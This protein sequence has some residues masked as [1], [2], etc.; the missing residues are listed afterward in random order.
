M[1]I[2]LL[3][4]L[5]Q[6]TV[7]QNGSIQGN[8]TGIDCRGNQVNCNIVKGKLHLYVDAGTSGGGGGAPTN[9]QY[10][11]GTADGTLSAEKNL[12]ALS[13]GLVLNTGG[14]P[15]AY[16]GASCTNQFPRSLNASGA[17]TCA[18]V[19]LAADVTGNLPVANLNSGTS[20]SAT[21][22]WRG[23]GTWAT[24]SSG[25]ANTVETTLALSGA[26][27]YSV[28]ITGQAWVLSTSKVSCTPFGTTSDGLT[29]EAVAAAALTVSWSNPVI[30]TGFT[31]WVDNPHGLSGTIRIHCTGA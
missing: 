8:A 25:S 3:V 4:L 19:S 31:V 24:P 12:G 14:T 15:S 20:A 26:G 21:T 11:V 27:I 2:L 9:A 17:A 30:S 6:F 29:P 23:D 5:S 22:F 1:N 28:V 7:Q 10:W 18:S 13:T 16:A